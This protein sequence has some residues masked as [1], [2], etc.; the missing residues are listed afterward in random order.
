MSGISSLQS[1]HK[2][3]LF[4]NHYKK[5]E[6]DLLQISEIKNV[7]IVQIVQYKKSQLK[8]KEI[9]IDGLQFPEKN[10]SVIS[11]NKTRILWNAPRTWLVVSKNEDIVKIIKKTCNDESFAVTDISH[12]R[13]IVQIKGTESREVLKKGSPLNY[14]EFRNNNCASTVFNGITILVD[15]LSENPD[16]FNIFVLR[17]FG[18]SFYQ[19]ITDASLEMG[20]NGI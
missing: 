19:S 6:S 3:G 1:I 7:I 2:K 15:L 18:E 5:K 4:G 17:S 13:A 9:Q 10:S 11:N 16:E 20:Y 12:S 8:L 14:N